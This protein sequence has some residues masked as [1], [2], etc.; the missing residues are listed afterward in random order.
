MTLFKVSFSTLTKKQKS[1]TVLFCV[2]TVAPRDKGFPLGFLLTI[3]DLSEE[4]GATGRNWEWKQE[5]TK[6][7]ARQIEQTKR[8]F[9]PTATLG[10]C[11]C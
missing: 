8:R 9:R 6:Q 3:N 5:Q 1:T 10:A 2:T 11:L 7:R 4:W